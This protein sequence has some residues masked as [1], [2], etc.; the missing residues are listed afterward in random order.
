MILLLNRLFLTFI[1]S[2]H[3]IQKMTGKKEGDHNE[4]ESNSINNNRRSFSTY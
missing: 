1:A 2:S 4:K 3:S